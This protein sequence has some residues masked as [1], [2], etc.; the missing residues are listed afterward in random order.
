[1][2]ED[3]YLGVAF[4][5]VRALGQAEARKLARAVAFQRAVDAA[6]AVMDEQRLVAEVVGA[7]PLTAARNPYGVLI[8][9]V[10]EAG[11]APF[12]D[13]AAPIS[14]QDDGARRWGSRLG[15]MV[16]VGALAMDAAAAELGTEQDPVVRKVALDAFSGIVRAQEGAT[17]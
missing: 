12:E 14:P 4:E 15:A 13:T 2:T 7:G 9:R 1:M 16:R 8:G 17:P 11:S 3:H 10:R 5:L 6:L